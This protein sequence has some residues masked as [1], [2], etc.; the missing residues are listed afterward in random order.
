MIICLWI[1]GKFQIETLWVE[2]HCFH[3][4]RKPGDANTRRFANLDLHDEPR[5]D[6]PERLLKC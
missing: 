2:N 6:G 5:F 4:I 1:G 3:R